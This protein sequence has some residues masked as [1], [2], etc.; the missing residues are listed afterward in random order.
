MECGTFYPIPPKAG[1]QVI[2][3]LCCNLELVSQQLGIP[4]R[5][6]QSSSPFHFG[7][8]L[9]DAWDKGCGDWNLG[10]ILLFVIYVG[11]KV[12]RSKWLIESL[13]AA[14]SAFGLWPCLTCLNLIPLIV[15][16]VSEGLAEAS[17]TT[18]LQASFSLRPMYLPLFPTCVS[19]KN[20]SQWASTQLSYCLFPNLR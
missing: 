12:S 5:M 10:L 16:K 4:Q 17:G 15:P 9:C 20:I 13:P 3:P 8:I 19:P 2:K 7:A 1:L 11:N 6:C 18:A 14:S